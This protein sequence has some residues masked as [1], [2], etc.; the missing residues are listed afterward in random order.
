MTRQ[1]DDIDRALLRALSGD[2]RRTVRSLARSVDLS[3]PAVRDRLQRLERDGV[4]T[5]YH[6]DFAPEAVDAGT[7]AF[8][9]LRFDTGLPAREQVEA[10][11]RREPC[12]LEAHEVAGED[13]YWIKVRVAST[14]ALADTLDRIRAIPVIRGTG[15]TIVLRTVFERPL[16]SGGY[17]PDADGGESPTA[18]DDVPHPTRDGT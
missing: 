9:A 17:P 2:G 10:A 12:V 16:L 7:A 5:G 18:A 14:A 13:C 4:I 3:E 6:A 15:T 8:I 1:L 11:I